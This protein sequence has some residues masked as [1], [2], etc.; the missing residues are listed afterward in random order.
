[1]K[2]RVIEHSV[3]TAAGTLL[4]VGAVTDDIGWSYAALALLAVGAV[5]FFVAAYVLSRRRP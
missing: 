3:L 4:V 2:A 5:G 1:M